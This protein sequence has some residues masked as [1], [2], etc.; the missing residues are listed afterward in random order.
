MA[1][2]SGSSSPLTWI[3]LPHRACPPGGGGGAMR[4]GEISRR[5]SSPETGCTGLQVTSGKSFDLI[6]VRHDLTVILLTL[7]LHL[8]LFTRDLAFIERFKQE[9]MYGLSAKKVAVV[10]RLPLSR[11]CREWMFYCKLKSSTWSSNCQF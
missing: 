4:G 6:F 1:V 7:K 9:S 11:G 8:N 10:E 5:S 2:G 3:F